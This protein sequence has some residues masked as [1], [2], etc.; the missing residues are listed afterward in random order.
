ML[1]KLLKKYAGKPDNAGA[2]R[3]DQSVP[4]SASV[5]GA[6]RS[7]QPEFSKTSI[8]AYPLRKRKKRVQVTVADSSKGIQPLS[9]SYKFKK[10]G[11]PASPERLSLP[12]N[13][14]TH[15]LGRESTTALSN[16]IKQISRIRDDNP[17]IGEQLA[18]V[19]EQLEQARRM[20]LITLQF[21]KTRTV[22]EHE[23]G[24]VSLRQ[25]VMEVL[26]RRKEWL[27]NRA[28]KIDVG[29]LDAKLVANITAMFLLIDELVSWAGKL[30]PEIVIAINP[31][32]LNK[33]GI[34]LL[35]FAKFGQS[36]TL[37]ADWTNVG[38]YLWHK[39]A[40]A[41]GGSAELNVMDDAL[42]V[43]VTFTPVTKHKSKDRPRATKT[44]EAS[45]TKPQVF[46]PDSHKNRIPHRA[47]ATAKSV[48][49]IFTG[50]EFGDHASVRELSH[51]QDIAAIVQGCHVCLIIADQNIR[52]A[53]IKAVL[54]LGLHI[55][56]NRNVEDALLSTQQSQIP[57]AVIFHSKINM[58]ELLQLRHEWATARKIAYLEICDAEDTSVNTTNDANFYFSS[59]GT[60]STAHVST[61]SIDDSLAPALMFELCKVL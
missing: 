16:S 58:G 29:P 55:K 35:V 22:A 20:A 38:W 17:F 5:P 9:T 54:S 6:K 49:H 4:I 40:T 14:I 23:I 2:V 24:Y 46:S 18:P 21:V 26:D 1:I 42:C 45:P 47:T 57:H 39:L 31:N 34:Q 8:N 36:H 27:K 61:E 60:M 12:W 43:S 50:V 3:T 13:D 19:I 51:D 44:E 37:D 28:I 30:A 59:I 11:H 53:V 56:L 48:A 41:V 32:K 52:D 25:L 10:S 33:K 15:M 7:S